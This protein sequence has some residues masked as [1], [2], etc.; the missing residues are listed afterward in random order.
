M[1]RPTNIQQE[2]LD[3]M[4]YRVCY[5]RRNTG[6]YL[7]NGQPITK[8]LADAWVEQMNKDYPDFIHWAVPEPEFEKLQKQKKD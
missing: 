1:T 6:E 4:L 8:D 7:G 3:E 5:R 2:E